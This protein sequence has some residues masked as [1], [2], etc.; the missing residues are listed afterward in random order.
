MPIPLSHA[1]ACVFIHR[2]AFERAGLH[3][4]D[5]DTRFNLTDNEFR[6]EKNLIVLGPLPS[7]DMVS[8]VIAE[9]EAAGLV[10]FDDFFELTG[11]WPEWLTLFAASLG[12]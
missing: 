12:E 7:D 6:I 5:V 4:S 11:N 9:L 3:R 2:T 8:T 10:Y 1:Q